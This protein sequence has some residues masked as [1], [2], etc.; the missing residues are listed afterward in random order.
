M[1]LNGIMIEAEFVRAGHH[2][3]IALVQNQFSPIDDGPAGIL[4]DEEEADHI[5]RQPRLGYGPLGVARIPA[6][7][8]NA[9]TELGLIGKL[10]IVMIG[11][12]HK[13]K[14]YIFL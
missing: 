14:K 10:P 12:P 8:M 2:Q 1:G 4:L 5:R 9:Q 11:Q 13:L 7:P 6:E 3:E